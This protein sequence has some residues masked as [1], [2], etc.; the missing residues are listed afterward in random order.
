M[1][2]DYKIQE[3]RPDDA[4]E[5]DF[6]ALHRFANQMRAERLPDDPP[7]S[8]EAMKA[9]LL[10][11][12]P[13]VHVRLWLVWDADETAVLGQG[14]FV[15]FDT[16]ENQHLGQVDIGVLPAHRQQGIVSELL[17]L[18]ASEAEMQNRRL[19]IG[20]TNGRVPAG[21]QFITGLG[22]RQGLATHMNQLVLAGLDQ[23]LMQSWLQN[24]P[25][26]E[27]TLGCW[28]GPYPEEQ[29][30]NI[31]ALHEVMNQQPFEDLEV[32][33]SRVTEEQ[34]RQIEANLVAQGV[35]RWTMYI[36]EKDTGNLAGYT[37]VMFSPDQ[38]TICSQGDTGV[39]H[40]YRGRG[41]G[42]WLK[43]AMLKKILG[44][45]PS[46]QFI[47]T[48]NADSNA[49]MLKINRALGFEPYQAQTVWQIETAKVGE[50]LAGR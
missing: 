35:V 38:T 26:A 30:A 4:T 36:Q 2:G 25:V 40:E 27:F 21:E 28:V 10:S 39:F 24:A 14:V 15:Y 13:F 19:L 12:P 22:G 50:Y 32:E 48:T 3:L 45:R 41:L 1:E 31:V 9:N 34:M 49:A 18:I 37:E 7:R 47:R 23:L 5:N 43:A 11:F 16:E 8:L 46:I 44:E 29:L 42:K 6:V 33:D 20:N 17:A